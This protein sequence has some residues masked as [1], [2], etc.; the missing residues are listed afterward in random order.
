MR[1]LEQELGVDEQLAEEDAGPEPQP[2]GVED[3]DPETDRRPDGGDGRGVPQRLPELR[4]AEV[5]EA[6]GDDA[7]D[8]ADRRPSKGQARGVRSELSWS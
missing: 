6:E 3:R 7:E 4:R 1:M 2:E 8:L 5:E